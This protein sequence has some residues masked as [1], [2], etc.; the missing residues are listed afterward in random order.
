[1]R[2]DPQRVF[3]A[4]SNP[5]RR[6]DRRQVTNT[7]PRCMLLPLAH[8]WPVRCC[9]C[10]HTAIITAPITDLASKQLRCQC[11]GT[12]QAFGPAV[13]CGPRRSN[14][15]KARAERRAVKAAMTMPATTDPR[16][17]DRL[18]HLTFAG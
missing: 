6:P 13:L 7:N 14:G 18:D 16:L 8:S 10:G 12:R 5:I 15:R 17:N 11:C 9:K 2:I 4:A 3:P 1:M